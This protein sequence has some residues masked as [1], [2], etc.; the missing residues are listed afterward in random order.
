MSRN[1]IA[2]TAGVLSIVIKGLVIVAIIG[3][4]IVV[5]STCAGSPLIQ[6]IDKTLPAVETAPFEVPTVTRTY[7]AQRA[8]A[9]DDGSVTMRNWYQR[10]NKKWVY[11][12]GA[13]TLPS[14]VKPR[15]RQRSLTNN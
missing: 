14:V 2:N 7:I 5:Y 1:R 12:E 8:T 4:G 6:S 9:N 3:V 11:Y 10:E 15:I 13:I